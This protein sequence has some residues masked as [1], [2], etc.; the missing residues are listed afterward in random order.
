[1]FI[2]ENR[3]WVA[4][5]GRDVLELLCPTI[6]SWRVIRYATIADLPAIVTI[7]NAAIPGRLAT[8]DT[9][10][11]TVESRRA[12]FEEHSADRRPL[13]VLE[14]DGIVAGW[15][16]FQSFY[17]H[18]AYHATAELSVYVAP[19]YQRRGIARE[20]MVAALQGAPALGLRTLL[21]FIFG[22]NAPSLALFEGFGFHQ[23]AHLPAVAELDGQERD[24][25]IVGLRLG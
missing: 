9:D 1:M 19:K 18:P 3:H 8:A 24:L 14:R 7:Y 22:H 17:G 10:F 11:V 15:L 2:R 13:L 20:L 5:P 25:I 23:W 21:G 4:A 16:S 6:D 12:W